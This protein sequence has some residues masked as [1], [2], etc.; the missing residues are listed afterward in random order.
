MFIDNWNHLSLP[1]SLDSCHLL[2]PLKASAIQI[3]LYNHTQ[4]AH[5]H[6]ALNYHKK[7]RAHHNNSLYDIGPD[8]GLEA[9]HSGVKYAYDAHHRRD[10][11]HIYAGHCK[12]TRLNKL[13]FSHGT[14]YV[15]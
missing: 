2:G 6:G 4:S 3:T 7:Y 10:D 8:D 14:T 12:I 15:P 1:L 13:R 11:V 9:A 5:I